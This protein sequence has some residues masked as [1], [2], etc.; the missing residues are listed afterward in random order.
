M[1]CRHSG[2]CSPLAPRAIRDTPRRGRALSVARR[3][4]PE[5][6]HDTMERV[7]R[8]EQ[9][10]CGGLNGAMRAIEHLHL[11]DAMG[12]ASFEERD[13][14]RRIAP[15]HRLAVLV[16]QLEHLTELQSRDFA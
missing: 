3:D 13:T 4:R 2:W 7:G 1:Y 6:G 11:R 9:R 16:S 10:I 14:C 12:G 5:H 15:A 8:A